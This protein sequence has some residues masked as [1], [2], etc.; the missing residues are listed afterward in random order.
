MPKK[1]KSAP[2]KK[3]VSQSTGLAA[4]TANGPPA[5]PTPSPP[6][7]TP[8]GHPSTP[9]PI[10]PPKPQPDTNPGGD[11]NGTD[12]VDLKVRADASKEQGNVFFKNKDYAKAVGLYT[13]AISESGH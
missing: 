1:K 5:S 8:D 6:T 2:S 3:S 13:E 10:E 9:E 12:Q 7:P 11:T 4:D